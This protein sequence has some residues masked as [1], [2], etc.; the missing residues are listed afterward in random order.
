MSAR[1]SGTAAGQRRR[2]CTEQRGPAWVPFP[3]GGQPYR[4]WMNT[5]DLNL[6]RLSCAYLRRA[7]TSFYR[8]RSTAWGLSSTTGATVI[9]LEDDEPHRRIR[10]TV[11]FH[12]LDKAA[13]NEVKPGELVHRLADVN[14]PHDLVYVPAADLWKWI[15]ATIDDPDSD[16]KIRII[17][18][19][20]G[21][22]PQDGHEILAL[23]RTAAPTDLRGN[24]GRNVL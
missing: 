9:R 12:S 21:P 4:L 1:R 15:G 13:T 3:V 8:Y 2:A 17:E 14:D 20:R 22:H 5:P 11:R 24:Y 16:G 18:V 10:I 7:T 23:G 19:V 6:A